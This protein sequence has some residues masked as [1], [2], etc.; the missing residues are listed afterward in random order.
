MKFPTVVGK[1]CSDSGVFKMQSGGENSSSG[2]VNPCGSS[3]AVTVDF[4][5]NS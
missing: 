4:P 2:C 5:N 1:I 3:T